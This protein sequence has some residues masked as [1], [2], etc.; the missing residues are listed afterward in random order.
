MWVKPKKEFGMDE[1]KRGRSLPLSLPRRLIGDL[2]HFGRKVPSVPVQKRMRLKEVAAARGLCLKRPSWV[3][4][5]AKAFALVAAENTRLRQS[6]LG[7]P[8]PWL[9]EHPHS[10]A[11][12]ALSREYQGEEAIFFVQLRAPEGQGLDILDGHLRRYKDR[13]VEEISAFREAL[14]MTR[15]PRFLRRL[16]WWY[17]LNVSGPHRARRFGTFG[18]STYSGL[19]VDSLHPIS[20]L[21]TVLN[22]GP[23][24]ADG[25]MDVR[26]IY[27]HRVLDGMEIGRALGRL[28]EIMREVIAPELLTLAG[29]FTNKREAA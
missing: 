16:A 2:L 24:G 6:F 19:G 28:E 29:A 26:L 22:Y 11:S 13:P 1:A 20:P 12:I 17:A 14:R 18:I 9:Y 27:D 10:I 5:F 25:T 15:L 7:F 4:L 21:T 23:I 8:T 3:V